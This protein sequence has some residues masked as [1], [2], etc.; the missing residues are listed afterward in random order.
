MNNTSTQKNAAVCFS[1]IQTSAVCFSWIKKGDLN[2]KVQRP[3]VSIDL[4]D[5]TALLS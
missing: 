3:T 4:E 5:M 2:Q 1:W